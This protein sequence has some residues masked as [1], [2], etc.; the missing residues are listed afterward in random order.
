MGFF[1]TGFADLYI[2]EPQIFKDGRGYFFES[3]NLNNFK[4]NGLNYNFVQ[5]NQSYSE[6]GT[7]RGLHFQIGEYAQA[8]LVRVIQGKV[9]D[10]VVDL[11]EYSK[12]FGKVYSIELSSDNQKQLLVPRGFA[13]GFSVLS[14]SAIF[15]YKVDNYY[16]GPSERGLIYNDEELNIDWKVD[17]SKISLSEKDKLLPSIKNYLRS[18]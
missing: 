14:D 12:T 18:C 6:Y 16:H 15:S 13:H 9:L 7:I 1:E 5:D 2:Y 10:V 8:K 4:K 3:Y 11:R 17:K